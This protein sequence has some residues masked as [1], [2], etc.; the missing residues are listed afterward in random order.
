MLA[1]FWHFSVDQSVKMLLYFAFTMNIICIEFTLN[2]CITK[3]CAI[4]EILNQNTFLKSIAETLPKHCKKV[5]QQGI[6]RMLL[7][8]K[9]LPTLLP[10]AVGLTK[11]SN[12]RPFKHNFRSYFWKKK[13]L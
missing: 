5:L 10:S 2:T 9:R 8:E 6:P 7:G 3:H 13:T 12:T 11:S 1:P 4:I